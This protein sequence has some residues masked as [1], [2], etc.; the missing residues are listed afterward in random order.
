VPEL[1]EHDA[2]PAVVYRFFFPFANP[3][4]TST[5]RMKLCVACGTGDALNVTMTAHVPTAGDDPKTGDPCTQS[6]ALVPDGDLSGIWAD[7]GIN[8]DTDPPVRAILTKTAPL[9]PAP[10]QFDCGCN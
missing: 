2:Q 3:Q 8:P 5:A 1:W 7:V 9:N 6:P 10:P 4:A